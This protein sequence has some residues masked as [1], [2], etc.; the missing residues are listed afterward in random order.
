MGVDV[1]FGDVGTTLDEHPDN[2]IMV[3][4]GSCGNH[5]HIVTELGSFIPL[6]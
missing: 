4:A 5:E 6:A 1:G 2:R 3:V